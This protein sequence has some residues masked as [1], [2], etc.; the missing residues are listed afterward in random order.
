MIPCWIASDKREY[1]ARTI[2][3]KI[4]KKLPEFLH[5]STP[6]TSAHNHLLFTAS[7]TFH[8]VLA[9]GNAH[10]MCLNAV[11][12]ASNLS[13]RSIVSH[14]IPSQ[15]S[16]H[17]NFQ[18][19][20]LSGPPQQL[21]FTDLKTQVGPCRRS[22]LADAQS[23]GGNRANPSIALPLTLHGGCFAQEFPKLEKQPKWD[24][25]VMPDKVNWDAEIKAALEKGK[26]VPEVTWVKPGEDEA[27]KVR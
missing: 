15:R 24:S 11:S 20:S 27:M 9:V 18:T 17:L 1:G 13:Q 14:C 7:S 16:R 12:V 21:S 3:S 2:R 19:V 8:V 6:C 5:V 25:K 4:H 10:G 26:E 23:L 22:A